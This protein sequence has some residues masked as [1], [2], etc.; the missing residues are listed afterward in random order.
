M[1]RFAYVVVTGMTLLTG[2][3][4]LWAL[5]QHP[6]AQPM[7]ERSMSEARTALERAMVG[8]ITPRWLMPR[9]ETALVIGDRDEI[10]MLAGLA[11]KYGIAL[12]PEMWAQIDAA[13]VD[14]G[15][16]ER[17]YDCAVCAVDIHSCETIAQI[18]ACAL[19]FE[20]TIAGDLN[21]LRRQAQ[22]ALAGEEIDRLE[23]GLAL[24]GAGATVAVLLSGGSSLVLKAGATS[25]RVAR[26]MG[27]LTP[28]FSRA[29]SEAADLPINWQA[30]LS[31]APLS[32]ITDTA[33]LARLARIAQDFGTIRANTSAA[34]A[35][36]LL[37][38]VDTAEDATKLARLSAV[39]GRETRGMLNVLGK[40]RAFRALTRVA[41]LTLAAIGLITA[42]FG[43][44]GV[45]VLSWLL[46]RMRRVFVPRPVARR[47]KAGHDRHR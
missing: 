44:L 16:A 11:T 40:A 1:R 29:L 25:L 15:F 18:A 4:A 35:L 13:R 22:A 10:E 41:D 33:K 20:M 24:V 32:E 19:P 7:V 28:G 26:N 8:Q 5:A 3:G 37:R 45:F 42:F 9:L 39:A 27:A 6:F 36:L 23:T 17:A 2:A 38:Y 21:A 31:G 43:Q 12:P 30:I 34:E 14:P 46:R 47:R